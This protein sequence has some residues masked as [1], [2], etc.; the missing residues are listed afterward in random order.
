MT[1]HEKLKEICDDIWY[2]FKK[3]KYN[4]K[5]L[6]FINVEDK[7]FFRVDIREILF[8]PEFMNKFISKYVKTY[9]SIFCFNLLKHK[10]NDPVDFLYKLIK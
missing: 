2:K 1:E 6:W 10:L 5:Y 7:H 9:Q 8:S 4:N 3:Y